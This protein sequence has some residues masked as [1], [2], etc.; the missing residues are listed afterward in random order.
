MVQKFFTAKKFHI[1]TSHSKMQ[2]GQASMFL[3]L[4]CPLLTLSSHLSLIN[5]LCTESLLLVRPSANVLPI[6]LRYFTPHP[7]P[8]RSLHQSACLIPAILTSSSPRLSVARAHL[9]KN[10]HPAVCLTHSPLRTVPRRCLSPALRWC[11]AS[12]R[13]LSPSL[14]APRSAR[15]PPRSLLHS[16]RSR[17]SPPR[18]ASPC[19]RPHPNQRDRPPP[20]E[21][22]RTSSIR[23]STCATASPST[24]IRAQVGCS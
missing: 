7:H 16:R 22:S 1:I 18:L 17:A 23:P 24:Q 3:S 21:L 20:S 6:P 15:R 13:I 5:P 9:S 8:P 10:P 4:R 2:R 12:C 19:W 11:P 14:P